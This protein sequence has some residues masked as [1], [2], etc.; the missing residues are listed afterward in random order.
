MAR[1]SGR[2]NKVINEYLLQNESRF[3]RKTKAN[4]NI[5]LNYKQLVINLGVNNKKQRENIYG[6]ILEELRESYF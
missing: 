6:K 2:F 4:C 1:N 5:G 3:K